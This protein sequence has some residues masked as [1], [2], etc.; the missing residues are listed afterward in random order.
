MNAKKKI[1]DYLSERWVMSLATVDE[2][3]APCLA[4]VDYQWDGNAIM[5]AADSVSQ[6]VANILRN[7]HAAVAVNELDKSFF[8][9]K[10]VQMQGMAVEVT[11]PAAIGAHMQKFMSKR[12]ELAKMPP[13]PNMAMKVFRITPK[14]AKFIDN[15][16]HPGTYE[17]A[18]Y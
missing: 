11:D 12:P 16:E 14:H 17:I 2:K 8:Q 9:I 1:S 7:P 4:T 10:G 15:T 6:K 18:E 5:F 13:N 3:G